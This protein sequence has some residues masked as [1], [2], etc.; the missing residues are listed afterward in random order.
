M[1]YYKINSYK[2]LTNFVN[3][4]LLLAAL[5]L[6]ITFFFAKRS[7]IEVTF[8]NNAK[9]SSLLTALRNLFTNVLVVFAWYLLRKRLVAFALILF[10]ADL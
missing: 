7:N 9:A 3:L 2:E 5:F 10:I 8:G 4:D 6:W 1:L